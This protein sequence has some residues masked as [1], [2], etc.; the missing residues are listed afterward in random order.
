MRAAG[1]RPRVS[2]RVGARRYGALGASGL[3][4]SLS[5]VRGRLFCTGTPSQ[6]PTR[7]GSHTPNLASSVTAAA[8]RPAAGGVSTVALGGGTA[9]VLVAASCR[10]RFAGRAATVKAAAVSEKT[11][12]QGRVEEII[13]LTPVVV[14]SKTTCP[15]CA[16]AKQALQQAGCNPAVVEL[17]RLKPEQAAEIQDHMETLTGART[18][19]RVFIGRKCIGGGTDTSNLAKS[20]QLAELVASATARQ[21]EELQGVLASAPVTKSEEEWRQKLGGAY[22]ILRRRGTE[23]PG[24]SEY[25]QFLP[26]KGYFACRG[27]GLPLYSAD[28]KFKSSCGWPVFD[29]CYTSEEVGCHVGTRTDGTGS[30]EIYCPR[31]NGHLGHVFFDAFSP[32]NLNGERH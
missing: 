31:C 30:L 10:R 5:A 14:I 9:A 2:T 18:V 24:S 27:C 6:A 29:R 15:F 13:A 3:V 20:G 1:W 16:E 4:F 12:L 11:A 17:D 19:P 32:Q 7:V 25:D 21:R 28:S 8:R 23:P 22:S 26:E